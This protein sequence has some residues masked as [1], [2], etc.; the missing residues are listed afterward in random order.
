MRLWFKILL[1]GLATLFVELALAESFVVVLARTTTWWPAT[2][3]HSLLL[4]L[5]PLLAPLLLA[6]TAMMRLSMIV[7]FKLPWLYL[8]S[9]PVAA[10]GCIASLNLS[11]TLF[12]V[13]TGVADILLMILL[14]YVDVFAIFYR[15][16]QGE[17][18]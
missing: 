15:P 18:I 14:M 4:R 17:Q 5:A 11:G 6:T 16:D 9:P 2:D 13:I 3:T 12:G 1:F 8:L 7:S 10:L